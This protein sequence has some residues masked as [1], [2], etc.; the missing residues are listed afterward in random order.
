MGAFGLLYLSTFK[1]D[2]NYWTS[3]APA[4]IAISLGLGMT[5]VSLSSTALFNIA[6]QDT[7]AASAVL[8]T[9]QQIGGSF[10]TAIQNT[11]AVSAATAFITAHAM[12]SS[13]HSAAEIASV[14]AAGYVHGYSVAFRFG[15]LMLLLGGIAF[16]FLVNIDRHAPRPARYG[17]GR[18]L[19]LRLRRRRLRFEIGAVSTSRV[20]TATSFEVGR[21]R[22]D[23]ETGRGVAVQGVTS[24][25]GLFV[26]LDD[27]VEVITIGGQAGRVRSED[28]TDGE[29]P[30]GPLCRVNP[31]VDSWNM[32]QQGG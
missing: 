7:G 22:E 12:G 2:S 11:L 17:A 23:E 1:V 10:G 32:T 5:F 28:R 18:S 25:Y 30:T 6:P 31:S 13:A 16:F 26:S 4:M 19:R 15:S 3:V 20:A 8:S 9:T 24:S 27:D 21:H 29:Q 14:K